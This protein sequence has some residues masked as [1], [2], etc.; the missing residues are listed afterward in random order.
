MDNQPVT[1]GPP[2]P[3]GSTF[4]A[5]HMMTNKVISSFK[6]LLTNTPLGG[7]LADVMRL[8]ETIHAIALM[9]TS[10]ECYLQTPNT[11]C[12]PLSSAH[13]A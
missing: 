4:N 7:L 9:G 1:S 2:H 13:L 5:R 12:S 8:G 6:S 3:L 10:K 11:P